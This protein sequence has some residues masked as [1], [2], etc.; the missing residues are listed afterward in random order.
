VNNF[1][2]ADLAHSV[3]PDEIMTWF[4]DNPRKVD[5][6]LQDMANAS[7][8]E[9]V[10]ELQKFLLGAVRE[11]LVPTYSGLHESAVYDLGLDNKDAMALGWWYVRPFVVCCVHP[12]EVVGKA[13]A[14]CSMQPN[15]GSDS[16]PKK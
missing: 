9:M 16:S 12:I 14:W 8:G 1:R 10:F 13:S 7:E 6:M 3:M 15:P 2:D 5:E 11:S 4:D